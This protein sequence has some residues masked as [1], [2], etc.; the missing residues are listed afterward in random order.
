MTTTQLLVYAR[1]SIKHQLAG[2][3]ALRD[4]ASLKGLALC[5]HRSLEPLV[6]EELN[7]ESPDFFGQAGS[8]PDVW[9]VEE[10]S[11]LAGAAM[12]L[13]LGG[14]GTMLDTVPLAVGTQLPVFGFHFGRLGFLSSAGGTEDIPRALEA[15]RNGEVLLEERSLLECKYPKGPGQSGLVYALNEVALHRMGAGLMRVA[16]T[17]DGE[18]LNRYQAD[19]LLVATPTGSTAYS[20]SCGG[21]IVLPQSKVWTITPVAGHQLGMGKA[22]IDVLIDDVGLIQNQIA[23]DQNRHLTVRVHDIDVFGLVVKIDIANLE[24]HAFFKQHKTAT[25]RKRAGCA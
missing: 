25:M 23:L 12:V 19:G 8:G 21:P 18:L 6:R 2:L 10:S 20:M 13:V 15:I 4:A 7:I 24:V 9:G 1:P 17:L 3:R 16:C 22:L 5:W 11:T 14:D